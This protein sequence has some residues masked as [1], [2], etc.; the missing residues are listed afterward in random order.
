MASITDVELS[1]V[2]DVANADV[3]I[4][5]HVSFDAF[6]IASNQLYDLH[7]SLIGPDRLAGEDGVDDTL[8]SQGA[9]EQIR[10]RADGQASAV[11]HLAFTIPLDELNEDLTGED[12]VRAVIG[13]NPVGPFGDSQESNRISLT[14]S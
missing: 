14:V 13:L 11:H 2:P 6:D 5:T 10:F 8:V 1:V 7:W 9:A 4:D 3:A 12:E